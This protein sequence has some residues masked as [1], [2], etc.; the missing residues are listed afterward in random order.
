MK[1]RKI[2]VLIAKGWYVAVWC[3]SY[4]L[5]SMMSSFA[6]AQEKTVTVVAAQDTI[7]AGDMIRGTVSDSEGP[8]MLVNVIE[9][10]SANRIV[11]NSV[12]DKEGNFSI[13]LVNPADRLQI[14]Y[15]GY[16]MVDTVISGTYY[17]IKM[18][19]DEYF[20]PVVIEAERID[21]M[22]MYGP[23]PLK[24]KPLLVLNGQTI[25]RRDVA[26]IGIDD[27]KTEYSKRELAR[28]FGIRARK[29]KD[30]RVLIGKPA[31]TKWGTAAW[32]GAIEVE[33]R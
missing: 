3:V 17:K 20:P 14:I 16:E 5:F 24:S 30:Y 4:S 10:D 6:S 22:T 18:K 8:M 31:V 11:A 27:K 13:R 15:P 23:I 21:E 32:F 19:V 2:K 25:T 33:T 26:W 29:I 28:I 1:K 12:T 7:K 9:R